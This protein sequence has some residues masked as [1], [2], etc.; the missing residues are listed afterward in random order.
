MRGGSV[1]GGRKLWRERIEGHN[2]LIDV[3]L[4]QRKSN[5][6]RELISSAFSDEHRLVQAHRHGGYQV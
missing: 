5:I 6:S 4:F 1:Y 2:K 3:D